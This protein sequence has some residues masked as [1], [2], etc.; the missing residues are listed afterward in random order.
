MGPRWAAI[1]GYACACS[2]Q[3]FGPENLNSMST[4]PNTY[5]TWFWR[6]CLQQLRRYCVHP[7][8]WVTA[9]CDLELWPFEFRFQN[10]ISIS[11]NPNTSI[12][13]SGWNS[14][15]CFWDMLFIRFLG[16]CLLRPWPLT[17]WAQNLMCI[18]M[19]PYTSVTTLGE[20]F[21]TGVW[22]M[23]FTRQSWGSFL[24]PWSWSC[25]LLSW[26][27][28]WRSILVNITGFCTQRLTHRQTQ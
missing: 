16:H 18:S 25:K 24:L 9:C 17:L 4:G 13:K 14:L 10:L 8:L 3:T 28:S 6:N 19:N 12:T 26:S 1:N 15:H 21:F 7:V 5:V 11:M 2:D 23:L 27:W 20:M 22:D